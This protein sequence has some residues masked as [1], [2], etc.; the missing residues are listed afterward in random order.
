MLKCPGY[1]DGLLSTPI[2]VDVK[3]D[4]EKLLNDL[5]S[6]TSKEELVE[7]IKNID[8]EKYLYVG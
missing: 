7:F 5:E 4:K 8:L 1:S 2:K 6:Y 3:L